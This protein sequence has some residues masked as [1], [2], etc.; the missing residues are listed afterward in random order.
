MSISTRKC[1]FP[2]KS[3]YSRFFWLVVQWISCHTPHLGDRGSRVSRS[4]IVSCMWHWHFS[5]GTTQHHVPE[6]RSMT[7]PSIHD[8]FIHPSIH[9]RARACSIH[10]PAA[11]PT[12]R[13]AQP[14]SIHLPSPHARP[15]RSL[16][17]MSQFFKEPSGTKRSPLHH[18]LRFSRLA[19]AN[20]AVAVPPPQ[21]KTHTTHACMCHMVCPILRLREAS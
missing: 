12:P 2:P 19:S 11:Q 14:H 15:T 1:P 18:F 20:A 13:P 17:K 8:S 5:A 4:S 21:P 3:D 9:A 16:K 10:R 6:A 7:Y